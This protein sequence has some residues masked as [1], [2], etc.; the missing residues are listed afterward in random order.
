[1]GARGFSRSLN[2][3]GLY[4]ARGRRTV[5]RRRVLV[6]GVAL[7]AGLAV[8]GLSRGCNRGAPS[9]GEDLILDIKGMTCGSC[10]ATVRR[11]LERLPGVKV[12]RVSAGEKGR[13][14][15]SVQR[16]AVSDADLREAVG[17][18]GFEL[19]DARPRG[20]K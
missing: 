19:L 11:E 14:I 2:R 16:A 9:G 7:V 10:E 12:S 1:M 8:V 13:A 6:A 17:K 5:D 4:R 15:I 18:A 20:E 3:D